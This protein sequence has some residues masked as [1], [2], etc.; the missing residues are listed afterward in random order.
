[1]DKVSYNAWVSDKVD[2]RSRSLTNTAANKVKNIERTVLYRTKPLLRINHDFYP[3]KFIT[4][5]S[6]QS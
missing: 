5:S 6:T 3:K 1:M 4:S 2:D